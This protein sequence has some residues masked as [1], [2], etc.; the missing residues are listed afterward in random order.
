MEKINK[1]AEKIISQIKREEIKP[2]SRWRFIVRDSFFWGAFVLSV[3]IGGMAISIILNTLLNND[4]DLYMELSGDLVQ[5]IVI[6]LP[7]FWLFL[8]AGFVVIAYLNIKHTK[9]A[10]RQSFKII[11]WGVILA[12]FLLGLTFYNLGAASYFDRGL[13]QRLPPRFH[14]MMDSRLGVWQKPERGFLMG[15]IQS[16]D[17]DIMELRD[18]EGEIWQI[19]FKSELKE[20]LSELLL[21]PSER[22]RV[23]GELDLEKCEKCFS[24]VIVRPLEKKKG[25]IIN[26]LD[27]FPGSNFCGMMKMRKNN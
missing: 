19:N 1:L 22:I 8:L 27:E 3:G 12:S 16:L 11:V 21:K 15:E 18:F 13:I 24:A 6:T 5:F 4:W 7:Y 14:Q 17:E 2:T 25:M 10:Y 9:K 20:F 26:C 23:M